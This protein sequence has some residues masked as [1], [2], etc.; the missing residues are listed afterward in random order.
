[1]NR[2]LNTR[3]LTASVLSLLILAVPLQAQESKA[4]AR[5]GETVITEAD[6]AVATE[7]YGEQLGSMPEDAR[8]SVLVDALIDMQLA[9]EAA[10]AADLD[11]QEGH[12][13]RMAFYEGQT[14]RA[15]YMEAEIAKRVDDDAVR[16]AYDE[17]A[18]QMP[19]VDEFRASHILLASEADA[20][21]VIEELKSGGD[22]AALARDRSL[23]EASKGKGGDLGFNAKGTILPEIE[24][25]LE[26]LS[27][28]EFASAPVQSPFGYHVV[29]LEE[30]RTRPAPAFE[31]MAPQIRQ[32][33][34][35]R[36]AQAIMA[37]LRTE[38]NVEKLVP[39]VRPPQPD[40]GH[41]H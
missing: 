12:K 24:A 8:R 41:D 40:D 29:R 34:E 4:V 21:V 7:M 26:S 3:L 1:M 28:G 25:S 39:D 23:D 30:G 35:A 10:R 9:K 38:T 2:S 15:A 18:A 6:L 36:A 27:P 17:Q 19:T 5:V 16:K 11:D 14:L 20:M 22:F 37:K 33:L 32:A 13:R 31:A